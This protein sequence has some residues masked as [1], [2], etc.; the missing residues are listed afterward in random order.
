MVMVVCLHLQQEHQ[1][2][3]GIASKPRESLI[4]ICKPV[5]SVSSVL[6]SVPLHV[7]PRCISFCYQKIYT[8]Y[9]NHRV[10]FYAPDHFI[11]LFIFVL[12]ET[13]ILPLFD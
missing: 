3:P 13:L 6:V 9:F 2:N 11:Y 12:L 7:P 8:F 1:E 10:V 4:L 5:H